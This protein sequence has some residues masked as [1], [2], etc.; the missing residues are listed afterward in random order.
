MILH[1][2]KSYTFFY[3]STF[4]FFL[5]RWR[6]KSSPGHTGMSMS[7]GW[8]GNALGSSQRS[9]RKCPGRGKS[10][11]PCSDSCPHDPVPDKRK[12]M[13][14]WMNGWMDGAENPA[15]EC[16]W[17]KHWHVITFDCRLFGGALLWMKFCR[18]IWMDYLRSDMKTWIRAG[19]HQWAVIMTRA[20]HNLSPR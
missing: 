10:G 1:R 9:Y 5:Q 11:R 15:A 13:D 18:D 7:L 8:P 17:G 2:Q 6:W 14:G 12:K 3:Q 4:L 20:L 16:I 19:W